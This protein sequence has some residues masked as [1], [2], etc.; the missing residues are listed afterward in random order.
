MEHKLPLNF[1]LDTPLGQG[2][3]AT[4]ATFIGAKPLWDTFFVMADKNPSGTLHASAAL[5]FTRFSTV[6]LDSL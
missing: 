3:L 1:Y 6:V 4:L 2:I 5:V